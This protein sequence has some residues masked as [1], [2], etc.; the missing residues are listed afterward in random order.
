MTRML[1]CLCGFSAVFYLVGCAHPTAA[2]RETAQVGS[3]TLPASASQTA[4][5][6]SG[7]GNEHLECGSVMVHFPFNSD[8]IDAAERQNLERSAAC[9]KNERG[10]HVTIEGN[11]DERGTEEYNLALGDR[12]AAAV[13][14]YLES[15]GAS[16]AQ[17]KTVSFGKENPVCETHDEGCWAQN[18]RAA[19]KPSGAPD[20]KH[21]T[22]GKL[23]H[24]N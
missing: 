21:E 4:T 6:S 15:L 8:T 5:P 19:V 13:A 14:R 18:R 24:K 1:T 10:L 20:L 22:D 7:G 16:S 3:P 12:R 17:I 2:T 23:P 11:A 9:L